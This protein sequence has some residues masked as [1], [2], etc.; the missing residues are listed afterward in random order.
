MKI[1]PQ[2]SSIFPED[3]VFCLNDGTILSDDDGEQE[4][5]VQPKISLQPPTATLSPAMLVV[6][7]SCNLANRSN[8]KFCKKCGTLL[9][10]PS[11]S[12]GNTP[13][14]KQSFGFPKFDALP[15]SP[16]GQSINP[17]PAQNFGE[18]VAVPSP[19]FTPPV[20]G[21]LEN[22]FAAKNNRSPASK[23]I[24]IGVL[25]GIVIAGGVVWFINR[26]H[27]LEAKLDKA[28]TN[29]QL[30]APNDENAFEFYHQLKKDGIDAKILEKYEDRLFPLLIEKPNEMLKTVAEPGFT[31]KRVEEWQDAVKKLEWAA[32]MRPIDSQLAAKANYCRGRVK[33]LSDQKDAALTDWKKAADLDKKWALPLNGIGLV[34]NEKKDYESARKWL[35]EA[36][37]REPNWAIPYNNLGS[38]FYFQKRYSEAVPY[39]RKALA[40]APRWAR[41]HA[42]L[43]SIAMENYE[44]QT[45]VEEF[46]QVLAPDA[47]GAGEMNLESIRKQQEK[48]RNLATPYYG[49]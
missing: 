28:I 43:G 49:Y 45:A 16:G 3:Y 48:A 8:S 26:P 32:E 13:P 41:P 10:I 46:D 29:N 7:A 23:L 21:S 38:S 11:V 27:P 37:E 15:L 12:A 14:V 19:P 9:G 6:C 17:P 18:T 35:L 5:V 25:L 31:E 44:Y 22:S 42:W 1:C 39:Y 47:V 33:Y 4:T 40:I 34:Y 2:C 20:F 24:F 30:L 36:V